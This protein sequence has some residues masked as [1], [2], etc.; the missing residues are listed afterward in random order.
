[1]QYEI[2]DYLDVTEIVV[3]E[4]DVIEL[5]VRDHVA[6]KITRRNKIAVVATLPAIVDL[7]VAYRKALEKSDIDLLVTG[8]LARA[9]KWVVGA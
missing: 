7:S 3:S 5:A 2:F 4:Y 8:S 1:M 9:R 6:S